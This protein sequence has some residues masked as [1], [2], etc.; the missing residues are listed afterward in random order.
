MAL[1]TMNAPSGAK[2]MT[3]P[4]PPS[5]DTGGDL[6]GR[7]AKGFMRKQQRVPQGYVSQICLDRKSLLSVVVAVRGGGTSSGAFAV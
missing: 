5:E 2:E 4:P 1:M 3:P 6:V 7:G